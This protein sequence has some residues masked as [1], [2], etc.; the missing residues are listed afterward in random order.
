MV[1]VMGMSM[2]RRSKLAVRMNM[3]PILPMGRTS[4]H[5]SLYVEGL[6]TGIHFYVI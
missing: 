1:W 5:T 6:S 2:M 4:Y 3:V